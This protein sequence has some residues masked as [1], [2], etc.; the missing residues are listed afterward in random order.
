[1]ALD[2][3]ATYH[4]HVVLIRYA[5]LSPQI[6]REEYKLMLF[7]RAN[8]APAA[9]YITGRVRVI[10]GDTETEALVAYYC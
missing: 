9:T 10:S 6:E 2:V 5:F 4:W 8:R 7:Y 1:M 3:D